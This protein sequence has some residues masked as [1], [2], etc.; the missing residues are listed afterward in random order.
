MKITGPE[1]KQLFALLDTYLELPAEERGALLARMAQESP[2]LRN[3]F[4]R[5]LAEG[6]DLDGDDPA[7]APLAPLDEALAN[8][9]RQWDEFPGLS[10]GAL[11]GPYRLLREIGRGGMSTVWLAARSDGQMQR[12]LALKLPYIHL[13]R[14]QFIER[15]A[16]EREILATLTHPNIAR[17]YDAGVSTLGQPYLAMEYVE[18]TPII[19]YCNSRRLGVAERIALFMQV[20][21]AVQFAHANLVVHRDLK[22]SNILVNTDGQ[23]SL[24]DFG[25]AKLMVEGATRETELTQLGGRALTPDYASPEQILGQPLGTASD[26]YSLG[27]VFYELL[28]GARPYKLVRDSRVSLEEAILNADPPRPDLNIPPDHAMLCATTP[29]ALRHALAGDLGTIVLKALKKKP[30]ERYATVDALLQDLERHRTCQPVLAQPDSASYRLRKFIA[31]NKLAVGAGTAS[32][33][34]ILIGAAGFAVEARNAVAEARNATVQRDRAYAL[35]DRNEAVSQFLN[36]LVTEAAQ[37]DTPLNVAG[38]LARSERLVNLEYRS[39]PEQRAAVL[40][41]LGTYYYS[42]G[43]PGKAVPLMNEAL[44]AAAHSNDPALL[45]KLHCDHAIAISKAG[46]IDV[47]KAELDRVIDRSDTEPL[48]LV[49][50][51][52][53]RGLIAQDL[54]DGAEALRDATRALALLRSQPRRPFLVE[55]TLME[56]I[57]WDSHLAGKNLEADRYYAAALAEYVEMGRGEGI[58]A[59]VIRNNWAAV[60]SDAGDP[61]AAL[62]L[63]DA[64]LKI[65]ASDD[66]KSS[67]PT[68]LLSNRAGALERLGRYHE[69]QAAYEY[70]IQVAKQAHDDTV[71]VNCMLGAAA[72]CRVAGNLLAAEDAY[73]RAVS[74]A[75]ALP[76]GNTAKIRSWVERGQLDLAEN[77]FEEARRNLT[78]AIGDR[79]TTATSAAALK[80][81]AESY[82]LQ[83]DRSAALRGLALRDAR[84]ALAIAESLQGGKPYSF[85]VGEAWLTVGRVLFA[86]GDTEGAGKAFASAAD[87]LSHTVDPQQRQYLSV[88]DWQKQVADASRAPTTVPTP[89]PPP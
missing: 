36:D 88:L 64:T 63:L 73:A 87:Q 6:G 54:N 38:L 47:A 71:A 30:Q 27:V 19:E 8:A 35:A 61:R 84:Q 89:R 70:C 76:N 32:M 41:M 59:L 2:A 43:N 57:G 82:L 25:I 46:Q 51:I 5:L 29:A 11:I 60:D 44:Q 85:R 1:W 26:V 58:E 16:R 45:G 28:A 65:I 21:R 3:N 17:L 18:G 68:Y 39:N 31:R 13:Q 75:A 10:T 72:I 86:Q 79:L 55:A 52:A 78:A 20:L 67:P 14:A 23:A 77:K 81:R 42:A 48:Q 49:Y 9:G 50:C 74:A 37:S 4:D 56:N 15:F 40:D 53:Y 83:D 34:A 33:L 12:D 80:S 66:P 22:P 24:L 62:E 7:L 69:A